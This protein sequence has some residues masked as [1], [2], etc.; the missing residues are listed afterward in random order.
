MH[1]YQSQHINEQ[2]PLGNSG[3]TLRRLALLRPPARTSREVGAHHWNLEVLVGSAT[4]QNRPVIGSAQT[5][6][7][8][9]PN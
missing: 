5:Q 1:Y 3:L 9:R 8:R 7:A 2:R 6:V 4:L